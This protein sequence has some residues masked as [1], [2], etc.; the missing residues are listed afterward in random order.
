MKPLRK[1]Q[2]FGVAHAEIDASAMGEIYAGIDEGITLLSYG[3]ENYVCNNNS[4]EG[5]KDCTE[6]ACKSTA[7]TSGAKG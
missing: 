1:N 4:I 6:A 7:C 2:A 3:C 5:R